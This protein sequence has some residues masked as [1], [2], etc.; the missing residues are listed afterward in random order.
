[1]PVRSPDIVPDPAEVPS[2]ATE[3]T[4]LT[5]IAPPEGIEAL[6]PAGGLMLI[7]AEARLDDGARFVREAVV[8]PLA[9]AYS[10]PYMIL[11]WRQGNSEARQP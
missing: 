2:D 10:A 5:T 3:P 1:M 11:E 4:A 9:G 8:E 7:R 6:G